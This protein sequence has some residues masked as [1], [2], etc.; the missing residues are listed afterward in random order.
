MAAGACK[1]YYCPT[2]H[3]PFLRHLDLAAA[4]AASA[5]VAALVAAVAD[6]AVAGVDAVSRL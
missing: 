5:A 3:P 6:A 2:N 1:G 4:V